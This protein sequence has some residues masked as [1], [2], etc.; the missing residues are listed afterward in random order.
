MRTRG[1][2]WCAGS[3]LVPVSYTHLDVYKRQSVKT[4]W[5]ALA[6]MGAMDRTVIFG[7]ASVSATGRVFVTMT[8]SNSVSYTHLDVYKR[9]S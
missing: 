9:Q 2:L 6:I 7:M 5:I 8:S 3:N 1:Q 4:S